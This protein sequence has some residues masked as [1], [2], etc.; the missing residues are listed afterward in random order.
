M[1][2]ALHTQIRGEQ[3]DLL[4]S[5]E[6]TYGAFLDSNHSSVASFPI[7]IITNVME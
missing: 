5:G 7:E 3:T 1:S 4:I 6:E 2:L